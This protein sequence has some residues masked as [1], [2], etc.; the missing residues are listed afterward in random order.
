MQLGFFDI[1]S[2]YQ[3][4]NE[5]GDPLEKNQRFDRFQNVQRHHPTCIPK[6]AG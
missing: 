4:L 1:V 5:L 6:E 2:K 3:R